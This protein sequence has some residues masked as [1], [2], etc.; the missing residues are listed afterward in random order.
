[1]ADCSFNTKKL[2]YN[3][4]NNNNNN[5]NLLSEMFGKQLHEVHVYPYHIILIN[6]AFW[7]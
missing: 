6:E 7:A 2:S 3:N 4:N 1:M 5:F